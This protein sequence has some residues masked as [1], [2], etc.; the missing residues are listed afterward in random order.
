[1][2]VPTLRFSWEYTMITL[3]IAYVD[4]TFSQTVIDVF[5]VNMYE[6]MSLWS[7]DSDKVC[8]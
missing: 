1:M 3:I 8:L 4:K 5:K 2:T 6:Y 7:D